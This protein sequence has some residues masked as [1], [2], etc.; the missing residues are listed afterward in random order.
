MAGAICRKIAAMSESVIPLTNPQLAP[1]LPIVQRYQS[2]IDDWPAFLQALQR[3]LPACLWANP[4]RAD[5]P[6]LQA[7]LE[8]AGMQPRP[9]SWRADA[10][11]ITP[12]GTLSQQWWY[13]IGLAH[14]QEE[15]SQVP[16]ALLDVQ[17][18]QRVWDMCAAPGG[19]T[20]QIAMAMVNQGTVVANDINI[21]RV[22]A[23]SGNLER[24]GLVNVSTTHYDAATY[25]A[26][27]GQFDRILL[28]APCSGEGTLRKN[29]RHTER[30]GERHSQVLSALQQGLLRKAVQRCKPGGRIVYST[31]TFAPEENEQVVD[32]IL[33]EFAGQ[34][35]L[36]PARI[37]GLRY[38]EGLTHWQGQHFAPELRN[39]LRLWPH[40]NDSGGFF[41]AMLQ[42]SADVPPEPWQPTPVQQADEQPW[43]AQLN[44]RF[45]FTH[46]LWRQ[47]AIHRQ[48]KRG[49]HLTSADHQPPV[50]PQAA[51]M[52]MFFYR[53]NSR[54]PKL[55]TSAALVLGH[56]ATR[57][58]V[59]LEDAQ[60][61][62][63]LQRQTFA[64]SE[65]QMAAISPGYVLVYYR[66]YALGLGV[67]HPRSQSLESQ[68][69]KK[70]CG[71][72]G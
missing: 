24:L 8:Q 60:L 61:A 15:V 40:Q 72:G 68:F 11:R 21:G 27:A 47:F 42:K 44:E 31:C 9:L 43:L 67:F 71:L 63:Y 70:W 62:G 30:M 50:R 39:C 65:T 66:G 19:K 3:P 56:Y 69:P 16:V 34:L 57:N 37:P 48:T 22:R 10:F 6:T 41:V 59:A 49:L 7:L 38:S 12:R 28:D 29:A 5:G 13:L 64:L 58:R 14:A 54:P 1:L 32:A 26:A 23:L 33:N 20:A 45:G 51:A 35:Q 46:E 4:L 25:P 17:P 52:G 53:T 18:G 2:I 36:L 55:S